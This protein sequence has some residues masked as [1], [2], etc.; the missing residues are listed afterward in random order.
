MTHSE[1]SQRRLQRAP[2]FTGNFLNTFTDV[3]LRHGLPGAILGFL[4]LLYPLTRDPLMDSIQGAVIAPVNYLAGGLV[5]LAGMIT[6]SGIRDK[7]WNPIRLGWILYLLGV[8]IW[9]EWV[10]R[11]ALPY[12]LVDMEVDFR[13][14]EI[15]SN[16]AFGLMHYFTLRWKWQWCLFA[17]L[18]G[19]GLSRQFHAQE[20]FLMIV[21]I[22]WIATFINTPREPGRRQEN[23]RA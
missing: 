17:F 8:S 15:A 9:E 7:K 11:V 6:F 13:V 23:F 20:D 5:I 16:L 1:S 12:V 19:V 18:G 3:A 4:V 22:H 2:D 21:A 14:S 10:F